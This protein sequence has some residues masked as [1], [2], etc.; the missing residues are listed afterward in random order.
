MLARLPT[1]CPSLDELLGG[2]VEAGA[3][4]LAYGEPGSGKTSFALQLSREVLAA[5]GE[6]VLFIDTEGLSAERLEQV[7]GG[8]SPDGLSIAAPLDQAELLDLLK[9]LK[10]LP[11]LLVIDTVNA[12]ARLEYALDKEKCEQ[13]FTRM[14]IDLHNLATEQGLPVLLTGQIYERDGEVGPYYGKSLVHMAKTL[15]HLEKAHAP[16][17]RHARLRKHR[18]LPEGVADFLLTGNGLE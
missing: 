15:L 3:L 18:S 2:G 14:V 5:G 16:G 12:H 13:A 10:E 7:C 11:A 4:T 17:L 1:G 8:E 9:A 6:S